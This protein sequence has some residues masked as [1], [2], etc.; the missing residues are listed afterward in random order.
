[1]EIIRQAAVA[2]AFTAVILGAVSII[3]PDAAIIKKIKPVFALLIIT[4]IIS[5]FMG[6][7][8]SLPEFPKDSVS[9]EYSDELLIAQAQQVIAETLRAQGADFQKIEISAD[10][11]RDGSISISSVYIYGADDRELIK[12]IVNDTFT[13]QEV[14]FYG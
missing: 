5:P 13:V 6:K 7:T 4:A 9:F 10:I 2:T 3:V 12:R 1:M 11:S 14:V 8:F